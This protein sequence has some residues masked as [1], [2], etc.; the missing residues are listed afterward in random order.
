MKKAISLVEILVSIV[1]IT[2]VIVAI[3]QMKE[4]NLFLLDKFQK[5]SLNSGYISYALIDGENRNRTI[6]LNH[7]VN[8]KD[9]E[10]RRELKNIKILIKDTKLK[11]IQV[12]ENEYL[13]SI[14]VIQTSYSLNDKKSMTE[15]FYTFKLNT[16]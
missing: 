2:T 12:P 11:D 3:L 14:A 7:S 9:D 10:I 4:N 5:S 1:L 8:F 6:Y 16:K 15:N 13:K